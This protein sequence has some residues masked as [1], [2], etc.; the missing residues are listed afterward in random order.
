MKVCILAHDLG[1]SGNKASLFDDSGCLVDTEVVAYRVY[2]PK[3]GWAEEDPE[4]WWYAVCKATR[5]VLERNPQVR[6]SAV[7]VSGQMMG[8]LALDRQGRP[9]G[10]SILWSDTRA[11]AECTG[12]VSALGRD[13]CLSITG[14][15]PSASY[16]LPKIVWQKKHFPEL[17]RK[18]SVYLQAKDF[19]N[20]R[21]TGTVRTDPTDAAYTLAFDIGKRAWSDEML[22]AAGIPKKLFP[23]VVP[24]DTVIGTVTAE[25]AFACGLAEGTPVVEGAG[26]GSAAHLGG[27][28]VEN[29]DSYLCLGS[30]TWLAAQTENLVF[31]PEGRMQSEPHVIPGKY[32]YVGTM[33]TGGMAWSWAR[34]NLNSPSKSYREMEK[35]AAASTAGASGLLFMPYLMGERSPY[36][37]LRCCGAFLGMRQGMRN[38][39][40]YRAVLEGVG[41]NLNILRKIIE[42]DVKVD[43]I[44]LIGGGGKSRLWQQILAD[45][46][47]KELLIPENT[48]AGTGIG[49]AIIAGVGTGIFDNYG[50]SRRF[51]RISDSVLPDPEKKQVYAR[52]QRIFEQAYLALREINHQICDLQSL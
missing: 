10:K 39:D 29:G 12:I 27:A 2:Y 40:L 52:K 17:Y 34:D 25:A 44:V 31:D 15:P 22:E 6:V 50:C 38:G 49:A 5:A 16:T 43:K 4:D 48:E 36:Y 20:Y 13:R 51:L 9:L 24:C 26:D 3:T 28:C 46:F 32:I 37:D 8:A 45:I 21:L 41:M 35:A 30:S 7:A 11:E 19:I 23:E 18:A 33:Q 1:T 42:L 14:Q 47:Q